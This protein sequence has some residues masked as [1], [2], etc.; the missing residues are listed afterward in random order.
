MPHPFISASGAGEG[1]KDADGADGA[2]GAPFVSTPYAV[3]MAFEDA[4]PVSFLVGHCFG[5]N[6]S[7]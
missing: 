5:G 1:A 3:G 7:C 2:D 6:V 4:Q